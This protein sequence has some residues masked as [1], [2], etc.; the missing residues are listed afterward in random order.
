MK[1]KLKTLIKRGVQAA[2]LYSTGGL[3]AVASGAGAS[4]LKSISS[5]T[6]GYSPRASARAAPMQVAALPGGADMSTSMSGLPQTI[7][8]GAGA[9][10][11]MGG[12][13]LKGFTD[14]A[15]KFVSRKKAASIAKTIGIE[16]AA[17]Y[18][19][20]SVYDLATA[21]VETKT[22]RRRGVSARQLANARRV[23]RTIS[24]MYHS[25]CH[26]SAHRAPARRKS[27]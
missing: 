24:K 27:C 17:T 6:A 1:F 10:T 25:L 4:A 5:G 21:V 19:G 8:R 26:A 15:G 12:R 13:A 20:I 18:L 2:A 16:A 14:A 23:N 3:S 11:R 22:H 9:V 7:V